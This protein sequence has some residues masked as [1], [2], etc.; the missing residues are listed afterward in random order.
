MGATKP[1]GQY[2]PTP[3]G[4]SIPKHKAVPEPKARIETV[5]R[6]SQAGTTEPLG[7]VAEEYH[8]SMSDRAALLDA[9][10]YPAEDESMRCSF[11]PDDYPIR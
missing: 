3:R 11:D 5:A 8:L 4:R 7:P 10:S 1:S 9:I 6:P 2:R